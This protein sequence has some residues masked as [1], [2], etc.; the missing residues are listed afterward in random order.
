[1]KAGHSQK[2]Q[3]VK[4]GEHSGSLTRTIEMKKDNGK[5]IEKELRRIAKQH[6][7]LLQPKEVVNEARSSKSPLHDRFEW[8]DS[9]A[10]EEY[11]LEQARQLIRVCVQVLPPATEPVPVFVSLTSDRKEAG[12]G[13]RLTSAVL[14]KEDLRAEMLK[15]AFETL[16]YFRNKFKAFKELSG[17]VSE[18]D[19]VLVRQ[20][21]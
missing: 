15:D 1:V 17:I 6:G 7:G 16:E 14:Q 20:V 12:G 2:I 21:R 11:R 9:I 19:K 8:D 5:T 10:A 3:Q 4:D 13:Y 18:I